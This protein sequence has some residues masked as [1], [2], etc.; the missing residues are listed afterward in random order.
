MDLA[1]ASRDPWVWGQLALFL[2]IGLAAPLLPRHVNLGAADFMLNRV[3]PLWL[4]WLGVIPLVF[5]AG[6]VVWG[7]RSLGPSLTPGTEPLPQGDLVTTG[8]YARIRHP[9][10]AGVVLLLAGYTL[11]WSNWTLALL[12]GGLALKFFQAKA[13]VEERLMSQRFPAYTTY[14]RH[15][16]RQVL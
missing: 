12:F 6:L 16:P 14:M 11:L 5:G 3:D 10:Y 4:R 8:A 1:K 7:I 13:R 2:G 9:I 15:V